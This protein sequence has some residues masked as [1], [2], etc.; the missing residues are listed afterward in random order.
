MRWS[1]LPR[2]ENI[3]IDPFIAFDRSITPLRL[4]VAASAVLVVT[5]GVFDRH[6]QNFLDIRFVDDFWDLDFVASHCGAHA[7]AHYDQNSEAN[8]CSSHKV[9]SLSSERIMTEPQCHINVQLG[10]TEESLCWIRNL[11][12]NIQH[13]SHAAAVN[14]RELS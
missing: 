7:G 8:L 6:A 14:L 2:I 4:I 13:Q 9:L 10:P 1:V 12:F 5:L 11:T 3:E